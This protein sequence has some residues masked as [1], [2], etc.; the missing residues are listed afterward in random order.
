MSLLTELRFALRTFPHGLPAAEAGRAVGYF[1]TP[2][3][4]SRLSSPSPDGKRKVRSRAACYSIVSVCTVEISFP[5]RWGRTKLSDGCLAQGANGL[6]PLDDRQRIERFLPYQILL[7]P[8]SVRS[9]SVDRTFPPLVGG[10]LP[11]QAGAA[12]M[13]IHG[14]S[15]PRRLPFFAERFICGFA[16]LLKPRRHPTVSRSIQ[17]PLGP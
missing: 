13:G 11:A 6:A 15:E 1:I 14:S 7:V 2:L 9:T 16:L 8:A 3:L 12:R 17:P 4:C 10:G 5:R